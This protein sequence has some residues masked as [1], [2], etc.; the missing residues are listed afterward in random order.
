MKNMK[1]LAMVLALGMVLSL[2]GCGDKGEGS[3]ASG[4]A[5]AP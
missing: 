2:A 3:T 4:S 1:K 5:A